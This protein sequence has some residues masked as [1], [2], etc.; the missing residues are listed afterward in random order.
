MISVVV[1]RLLRN[2]PL[3]PVNSKMPRCICVAHRKEISRKGLRVKLAV[4]TGRT[5]LHGD[6]ALRPR[7]R[8]PGGEVDAAE[9]A[10]DELKENILTKFMKEEKRLWLAF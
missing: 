2:V 8:S 6:E 9:V 1:F 10:K 3:C 4:G 7:S 5:I